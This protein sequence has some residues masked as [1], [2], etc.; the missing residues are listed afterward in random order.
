MKFLAII[1]SVL[2]ITLS[3][4]P[5]DDEIVSNMGNIVTISAES[6]SEDFDLGDLCSPFC[7]CVCC[8]TVVIEPIFSQE[9]SVQDAENSELNTSYIFSFSRDFSNRIFQ[10]PR[11]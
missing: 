7:T 1:L 11:V 5:C 2:T 9:D 3:A 4:I 8:A 10:P 6:P